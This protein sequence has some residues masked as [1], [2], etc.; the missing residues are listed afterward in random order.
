MKPDQ[1]QDQEPEPEPQDEP[2][3]QSFWNSLPKRSLPRVLLLLAMLA[4]I[5]YLRQR[6]EAIAGCMENAFR[7]PAAAPPGVRLKAPVVLPP[8]PS[9]A[10]PR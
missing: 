4:G 1:N 6:T 2:P 8:R 3:R 10:A 7:M 5:L 9:Q